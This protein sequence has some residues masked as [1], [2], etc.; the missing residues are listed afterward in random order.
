MLFMRPAISALAFVQNAQSG[1]TKQNTTMQSTQHVLLP[2]ACRVSAMN[3][4][5]RPVKTDTMILS[6]MQKASSH[7][8][9]S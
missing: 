4:V 8:S 9:E 6:K 7:K 1:E 3:E 5:F 2:L